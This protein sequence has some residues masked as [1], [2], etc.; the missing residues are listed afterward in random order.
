MGRP[1]LHRQPCIVAGIVATALLASG[2]ARADTNGSGFPVLC[3]LNIDHPIEL[4]VYFNARSNA[5]LILTD[6]ETGSQLAEFTAE[7]T[8][9][10]THWAASAG[11]RCIQAIATRE[12][13]AR[14]TASVPMACFAGDQQLVFAPSANALSLVTVRYS[15]AALLDP[16]AACTPAEATRNGNGSLSSRTPASA[17]PPLASPQ[18]APVVA[19]PE[20]EAFEPSFDVIEPELQGT[21]PEF[22]WPPPRPSTRRLLPRSLLTN[23]EETTTFG[24]VAQRLQAALEQSGYLEYGYYQ[25][26]GG[27]ALATRL[28]RIH[29]SGAAYSEPARWALG[30]PPVSG[31]DLAA[32]LRALFD[33]EQGYFRVIVFAVTDAPYAATGAS[34]TA[35]E[36]LSWP[37]DGAPA[38]PDALRDKTLP[39]GAN[40]TSLVY[41]FETRGRG[42]DARFRSPSRLSADRHL[43]QSMILQ[44]LQ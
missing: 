10:G 28:E 4:D 9:R 15:R 16:Q 33:V 21:V 44:A 40:A 11:T 31:F 38:L 41:E 36:A 2:T 14:A 42:Q 18:P 6:P 13:V 26:P 29:A 7:S 3:A 43:R 39:Q 19:P 1:H 27:F 23:A 32:Y 25:I 17:P 8:E 24:T 5:R 12:S 20:A 22:P 30:P 35:E 37:L 34:P